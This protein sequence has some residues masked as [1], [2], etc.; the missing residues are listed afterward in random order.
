MDEKLIKSLAEGVVFTYTKKNPY[1]TDEEIKTL[2]ETIE[3]YLKE[4]ESYDPSFKEWKA[5]L[6]WTD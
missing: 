3:G 4:G 1:M 2:K 6:S 5:S